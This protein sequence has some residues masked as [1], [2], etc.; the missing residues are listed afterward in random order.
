MLLAVG[1]WCCCSR[2]S[3]CIEACIFSC[4]R[5]KKKG[6]MCDAARHAKMICKGRTSETELQQALVPSVLA[7]TWFVGQRICRDKD[8]LVRQALQQ[9]MNMSEL[10]VA[11]MEHFSADCPRL[12][13]FD[14][15]W[16]AG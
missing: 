11:G 9:T 10:E 13:Y 1:R 14:F 7:C 6:Q 16:E 12:V 15:D 8:W 4:F 3:G 2:A 5:F